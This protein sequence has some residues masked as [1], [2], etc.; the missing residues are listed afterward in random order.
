MA[1]FDYDVVIIARDSA[2]AS[3]FSVRQKRAT[4][5]ASWTPADGISIDS[6]YAANVLMQTPGPVLAV[7]HSD[8][9]AV[10]ASATSQA[11]NI[12]GLVS[13]AD[14]EPEEG[15]LFGDQCEIRSKQ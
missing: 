9:G 4:A 1:S 11:K 13:V 2:G 8:G 14:F 6:G 5:S 12:V 3:P 7:G 10:I 15:E